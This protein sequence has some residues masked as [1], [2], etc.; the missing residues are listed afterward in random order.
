MLNVLVTFPS[1][2]QKK[3][4]LATKYLNSFLLQS[5]DIGYFRLPVSAHLLP[6]MPIEPLYIHTIERGAKSIGSFDPQ[7]QKK[8]TL[9]RKSIKT[10][11]AFLPNPLG[12][13]RNHNKYILCL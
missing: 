12:Q 13:L 2:K 11:S 3:V 4:A 7:R 1:G 6:S 10:D 9:S 5:A 8:E